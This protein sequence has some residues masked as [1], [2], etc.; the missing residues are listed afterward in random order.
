MGS[1]DSVTFVELRAIGVT[2]DSNDPAMI[3]DFWQRA[4]DL[5]LAQSRSPL[6][7]AGPQRLARRRGTSRARNGS[8]ARR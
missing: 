4:M 6:G 7:T 5:R 3:A 2:L 1:P 8:A